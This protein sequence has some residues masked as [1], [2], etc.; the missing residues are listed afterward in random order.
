[1]MSDMQL[2]LAEKMRLLNDPSL[3]ELQIARI[4]INLQKQLDLLK[5]HETMLKQKRI[6]REE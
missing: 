3:D 5:E 6:I 2:R 4:K 1:M